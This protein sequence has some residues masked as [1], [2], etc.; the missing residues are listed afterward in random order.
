MEALRQSVSDFTVTSLDAP[1]RVAV[2]PLGGKVAVMNFTEL[3]VSCRLVGMGG[4]VSRQKRVF[5]TGGALLASDGRTLRLPPH[6]LL[7]VE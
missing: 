3:S 7:V 2:F 5:A 4:M 1:P 6:T